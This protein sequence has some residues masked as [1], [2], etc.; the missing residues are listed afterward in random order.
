[1]NR[2]AIAAALGELGSWQQLAG[3]MAVANLGPDKD[4]CELSFSLSTIGCFLQR[5]K[6]LAAGLLAADGR[7]FA[8]WVAWTAVQDQIR[9]EEELATAGIRQAMDAIRHHLRDTMAYLNEAWRAI[10]IVLVET[11]H[12]TQLIWIDVAEGA[13]SLT[14]ERGRYVQ[15]KDQVGFDEIKSLALVIPPV[16]RYYLNAALEFAL[17]RFIHSAVVQFLRICM[18]ASNAFQRSEITFL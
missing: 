17:V 18:C 2:L 4:V 9:H 7:L 11:D 5:Y 10:D 13:L 12:D 16:K 15:Y 1:M 8:A 14:S 6:E 3:I